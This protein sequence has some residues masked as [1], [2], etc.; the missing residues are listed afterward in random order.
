MTE[1][2]IFKLI[3]S[4][5]VPLLIGSLFQ[6]LYNV[7][8]SLV[9]GNFEGSAALAAVGIGHYPQNIVVNFFLGLGTGVTVLVSQFFGAADERSV[10]KVIDTANTLILAASPILMVG[11]YF[12][13]AP[14]LRGMNTPDDSFAEAYAY[15]VVLFLGIAG[16]LGYNLNAGILRGMGDSISPLIFLIIAC[17]INIVLDLLFIGWFGWSCL[18]AGLATIIAQWCSWIFSILFINKKYPQYK[19]RIWPLAFHKD[20]F[21]RMMRIGLP[22][23][24]NSGLFALGH[25]MLSSLVNSHGTAFAAGYNV[26]SKLDSITWL[27]LSSF[28]SAVTTFAGQNVGAGKNDRL[29]EGLKKGMLLALLTTVV[30]TLALVLPAPW[31]FSLFDNNPAVIAAGTAAM[32]RFE[33]LYV[34]YAVFYVLTCFLNGVGDVKIPFIANLVLFWAIRLPSAYALSYFF[35]PEDLFFCYPISWVGGL[36]IVL[37]YFLSGKWKRFLVLPKE[38]ET[39]PADG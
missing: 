1:G 27:G 28:A 33:P 20:V 7:V 9:I 12:L 31:L 25:T 23:A 36:A 4:F 30:T 13:T 37:P 8:D 18:G 15:L 38:K 6:L 34:I 26:C 3:V 21:G 35:R 2:N 17:G 11:G 16:T 32:Y 14:I 39:I 10:K 22:L 29:M 5:A 19:I 24:F